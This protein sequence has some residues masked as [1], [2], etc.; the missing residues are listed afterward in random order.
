VRLCPIKRFY[1]VRIDPDCFAVYYLNSR[2]RGYK[3]T[4]ILRLEVVIERR[5][6]VGVTEKVF[7]Y[8]RIAAVNEV[9]EG[10]TVT[11]GGEAAGYAF[12]VI[13]GGS[14]GDIE[15]IVGVDADNA[16][17]GVSVVNHKET[18]GIGTKVMGDE[19]TTSGTG[20][21]TQFIGKSGAGS[22]VVKGGVDAVS[23]A[24]VSTKGVTKGVNAALAAAE[25]MG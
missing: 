14:Q 18:S 10:Y 21:L 15:M 7:C 23:G 9:T 1:K 19:P 22:L 11:I 12:K 8:R 25:A 3:P 13:A 6:S 2:N 16:V 20:A 24:T 4:R 5:K 17:T